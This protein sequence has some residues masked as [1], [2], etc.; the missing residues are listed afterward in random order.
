MKEIKIA[1]KGH[2]NSINDNQKSVIDVIAMKKENKIQ[3]ILDNV[4]HKIELKE[5]KIILIRENNEFR[6]TLEF[7]KGKKNKSYYLLKE[8]NFCVD[9]NI[10]TIEL[11]YKDN[12]IKI[13]Y[14]VLDS[15]EKYEYMLEMRNI[16]EYK[17]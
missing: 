15:N 11:E 6:S 17:K 16:D 14:E 13:V 10:E 9:I 4:T 8:K 12:F 7:I 1:I 3:Y 5:N 2:L